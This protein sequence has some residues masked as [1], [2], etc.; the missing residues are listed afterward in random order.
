MA[1]DLKHPIDAPYVDSYRRVCKRNFHIKQPPILP[2]RDNLRRVLHYI[3]HLVLKYEVYIYLCVFTRNSM[4][5]RGDTPTWIY[6]TACTRNGAHSRVT[7]RFLSEIVCSFG[8]A[9]S[10]SSVVQYIT[11]L[12]RTSINDIILLPTFRACTRMCTTT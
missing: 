8:F 10:T 5:T 12:V 11:V 7:S 4:N 1:R 6:G 3:S 9:F 2:T